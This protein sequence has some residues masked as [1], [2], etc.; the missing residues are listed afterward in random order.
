M[1]DRESFVIKTLF[2]SEKHG[3]TTDGYH[4]VLHDAPQSDVSFME[5][6]IENGYVVAY[7]TRSKGAGL[8]CFMFAGFTPKGRAVYASFAENQ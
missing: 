7:R 3:K 1:M 5:Q 8:P 4:E 2:H 6:L